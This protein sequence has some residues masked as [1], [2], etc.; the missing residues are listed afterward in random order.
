LRLVSVMTKPRLDS[1]AAYAKRYFPSLPVGPSHWPGG[2]YL[3]RPTERYRVGSGTFFELLDAQLAQINGEYEY[4]N[5]VY[6]YHKAVAALEAA[7]GRPL[8]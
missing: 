4:V 1:M 5:A 6:L 8:R 7:V 3:W 2:Y